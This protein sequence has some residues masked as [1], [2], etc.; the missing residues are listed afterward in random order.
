M[1]LEDKLTATNMERL[2]IG[3]QKRVA[4]SGMAR[5]TWELDRVFSTASF[6]A[7]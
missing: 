7:R 3:S 1:S 2:G 4:I 6:Q 5:R